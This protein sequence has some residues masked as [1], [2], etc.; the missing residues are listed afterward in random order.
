MMTIPGAA[1]LGVRTSA[2]DSFPAPGRTE[3]RKGC[4]WRPRGGAAKKRKNTF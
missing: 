3:T 1:M 2:G 4:P